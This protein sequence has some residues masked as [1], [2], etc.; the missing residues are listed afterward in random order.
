MYFGNGDPY[1]KKEWVVTKKTVYCLSDETAAK[2]ANLM[3]REDLGSIPV[4]EN[5]KPRVEG[6]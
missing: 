2:K 3:K 5:E 1:E 6:R 4:I